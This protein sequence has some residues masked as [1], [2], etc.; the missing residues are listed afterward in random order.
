MAAPVPPVDN[1][2]QEGMPNG[3][4]EGRRDRK[5]PLPPD[6]AIVCR[7]SLYFGETT[8]LIREAAG[9]I[10]HIPGSRKTRVS[11]RTIERYLKNYRAGGFEALMPKHTGP[12]AVR[13]PRNTLI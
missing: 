12:R 5:F 3:S 4:Q 9:K 13:V 1:R 7:E 8:Q 2:L 6:L 11:V 10:Y